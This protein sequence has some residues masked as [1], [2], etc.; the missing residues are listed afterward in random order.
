MT[1][2]AI[3]FRL[4]WANIDMSNPTLRRHAE[5]CGVDMRECRDAARRELEDAGIDWRQE[6]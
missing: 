6:K 5:K 1:E 4:G 2:E 3:N